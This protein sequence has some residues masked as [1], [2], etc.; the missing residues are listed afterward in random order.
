MGPL[1]PIR[2]K[3]ASWDKGRRA[4]L[5]VG[6]HLH[7]HMTDSKAIIN[8]SL[9]GP[10]PFGDLVDGDLMPPAQTLVVFDKGIKPPILVQQVF[11]D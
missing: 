4:D 11:C 1:A 9:I 6:G 5:D 3:I 8:A 7:T 2:R 10:A